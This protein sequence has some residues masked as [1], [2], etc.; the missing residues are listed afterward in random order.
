M[1]TEGADL[2]PPTT[3]DGIALV[4]GADFDLSGEA[5]PPVGDDPVLGTR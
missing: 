1:M 4:D 3:V 5:D 2:G